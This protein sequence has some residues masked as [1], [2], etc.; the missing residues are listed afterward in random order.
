MVVDGGALNL[1]AR[2]G[3]WWAAQPARL[4][5]DAAPGRVPRLMGTPPA[6]VMTGRAASRQG[7]GERFGQVVVLKGARTVIATPDGQA[8][9]AP[10]AN[11]ALATAGSGDVLAG[12]IG[13]LLAQSW[14]RSTPPAWACGSTAGRRADQRAAG[15]LGPDRVRPAVRDRRRAARAGR[16]LPLQARERPIDRR[17]AGRGRAAVAAKTRLGGDRRS[18]RSPATSPPCAT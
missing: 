7:R 1:L 16:H 5:A 4:R 6:Q 15:R 10:F 12:T 18:R 13:S 11:A 2:S 14:R 8:A 17:A 3:R 9:V